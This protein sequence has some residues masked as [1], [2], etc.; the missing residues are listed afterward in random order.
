VQL[1]SPIGYS[2]FCRKKCN[3]EAKNLYNMGELL[4]KFELLDP[5]GKQ[6]LLDY[7]DFL[8]ARRRKKQEKKFDYETYL[9]KILTISTWSDEEMAP[10]EEA[11]QLIS[12][13]QPQQ[14]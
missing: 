3:F 8:I 9:Q 10:V 5:T 13:W 2:C 11:H 6:E 14:W 7:L 12:N 1:S 4:S